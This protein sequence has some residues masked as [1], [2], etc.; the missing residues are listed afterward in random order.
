MI[1]LITGSREFTDYRLFHDIVYD[2]LNEWYKPK[3][4]PL[5]IVS[6]GARGTDSLAERFANDY[7]VNTHII[8]ADWD[9]DGK[10]AG[11]IRNGKI[12]QWMTKSQ[13]VLACIGF[14]KG[15]SKG[16]KN[17]LRLVDRLNVKMVKIINLDKN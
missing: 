5:T 7:G 17:M 2:Q 1:L 4:G 16:T 6:G 8:K 15:E 11:Y 3:Y 9:H 10:S 14:I 12:I 13:Q